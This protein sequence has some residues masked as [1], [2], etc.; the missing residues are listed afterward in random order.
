MST[1]F[2]NKIKS[3]NNHMVELRAGIKENKLILSCHYFVRYFI[4]KFEGEFT[5][6]ELQE[7]VDFFRQFQQINQF[8]DEIKNNKFQERN[9][10]KEQI[11]ELED[12]K[13][14]KVIINLASNL[15][16][17]VDFILIKKEKTEQEKLEEYQRV[18]QIYEQKSQ[19]MGI[20]SQILTNPEQRQYIK[21]WINPIKDVYGTLLYS[22]YIN[23][24]PSKFEKS[25]FGTPN[26][27]IKNDCY[28][29]HNRC[30]NNSPLLIVCKSGSQIFGGFTELQ[31]KSN[32]TY[33]KDNDSFLFSLNHGEKFKKNSFDKNESIWCYKNYGPCFHYDLEFTENTINMVKS[34]RTNYL[35]PDN[36]ILKKEAKY[37]G[38]EII[39][40]ALEIYKITF[41]TE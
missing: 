41:G 22:F 35:I 16:K 13:Q 3:N 37:Y 39:L 28:K 20:N 11:I 36:F 33:G 8:L 32:D 40:E 31:F 14:L 30:D 7:R 21:S 18:I 24:Y 4:T 34:S 15:Y 27:E 6:E 25:F 2:I 12:K 38:S 9:K 19:I 26:W 1:I 10:S 23:N 5:L 29:F 17:Y